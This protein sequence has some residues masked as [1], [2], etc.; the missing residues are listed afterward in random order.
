MIWKSGKLKFLDAVPNPGTKWDRYRPGLVYDESRKKTVLFGGGFR[1]DY[2]AV[3]D[4]WEWDGV[5][6]VKKFPAHDP[7]VKNIKNLGY[8]WIKMAWDPRLGKTVLYTG[9]ALWLWDGQD[10]REVPSSKGPPPLSG[11][12]AGDQFLFAF[13]GLLSGPYRESS[14]F[15]K[16]DGKRWQVIPK[17]KIWPGPRRSPQMVWDPVRKKLV[18][19]GGLRVTA[20]AGPDK[21]ASLTDLWEWDG[22]RW[23]RKRRGEVMPWRKGARLCYDS[24]RRRMVCLLGSLYRE[25]NVEPSRTWEWD[26]GGWEIMEPLHHPPVPLDNSWFVYDEG[27]KVAVLFGGVDYKHGVIYD[28][29]WEWNGKD[30]TRRSPAH[31]PPARWQGME[32]YDPVRKVCVL[33]GGRR[34][35]SWFHDTWEWDGKDWKEIKGAYGPVWIRGNM[36]WRPADGK[37]YWFEPR[38]PSFPTADAD[39]LWS[40]DGKA[41]RKR[42]TFGYPPYDPKNYGHL[43]GLWYDKVEDVFLWNRI[44]NKKGFPPFPVELWKLDPK[45]LRWS[46]TLTGGEVPPLNAIFLS[47]MEYDPFR[48]ELVMVPGSGGGYRST[49]VMRWEDIEAGPE[50]ILGTPLGIGLRVP[51]WPGGVYL[52]FLSGGYGPGIPLPG[53]SDLPL[54]PDGIFWN[55]LFLPGTLGLLDTRGKASLSLPTPRDPVL[56]SLWLHA[57]ALVL[58]PK[59]L[60]PAYVTGRRGIYLAW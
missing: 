49:W 54:A 20:P 55:S 48:R 5:K 51:G 42:K 46:K 2:S 7:K 38:D 26:G 60:L 8:D 17:Q 35:A 47:Q 12:A 27:R 25:P 29:T 14:D 32:G 56:R 39:Y 18:L 33:Y 50:V 6:W 22:K 44:Q 19:F 30:W 28:H 53:L 13:G 1:K 3:L 41:W 57:A 10:W 40:W 34:S 24:V 9:D 43:D 23:E 16:W 52:A 15:W 4:T 59:T 45:T 11:F 58:S 31:R 21:S 36:A 37:L